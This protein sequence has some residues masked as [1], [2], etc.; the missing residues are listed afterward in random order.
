[1]LLLTERDPQTYLLSIP[2]LLRI[3]QRKTGKRYSSWDW[4]AGY[5]WEM[6]VKTAVSAPG[7]VLLAGGY[8]VLDRRHTGLVFGLDA[9]IHVLVEARTDEDI[10]V[11]SPQFKDAV[12]TYHWGQDRCLQER[13]VQ[14]NPFVRT[15]LQY[16]LSYLETSTKPDRTSAP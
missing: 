12:W 8:L 16:A 9:R 7:K 10:V 15:A 2:I 11:E 1:M 3:S 4:F 5:I 14:Q 6:A 13:S